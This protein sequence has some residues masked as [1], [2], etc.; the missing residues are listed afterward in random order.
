M[1]TVSILFY[2]DGEHV[3]KSETL[4]IQPSQNGRL[5][6]PDHHKQNRTIVAVCEGEVNIINSLG[7][8]L[9][10]NNFSLML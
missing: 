3:L 5:I 1:K 9:T 6:I 4:T 2:T 8:R 10:V 7:E